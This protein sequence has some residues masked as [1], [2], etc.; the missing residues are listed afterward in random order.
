MTRPD[1]TPDPI[2]RDLDTA[3]SLYAQL[4][5]RVHPGNNRVSRRTAPASRPPVNLQMVSAMA[6][7]ADYLAWWVAS[8]RWLLD[9]VGKIDL[10]TRTGARCPYDGGDLVAWIRASDPDAAE[11]VCTNLDHDD[12]AGPRRWRKDQWPRL[13]VLAGVHVDARFGPRLHSVGE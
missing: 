13:G 4:A 7:L 9:P 10:T 12:E 2:R 11:I 3:A 6:E 8:A 5:A 1:P